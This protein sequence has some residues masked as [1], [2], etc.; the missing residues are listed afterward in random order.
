VL[1]AAARG[2]EVPVQLRRRRW[3]DVIEPAAA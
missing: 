2:E 3:D 1:H